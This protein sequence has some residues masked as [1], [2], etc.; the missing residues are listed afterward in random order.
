MI[1]RHYKRIVALV[2]LV[3]MAVLMMGA[4]NQKSDPSTIRIRNAEDLLKLSEECKYDAYSK[5]KTVL[6]EADI[7]LTEVD[8]VPIPTFG[9]TFDGQGH[10]ISGL[11]LS[12]DGRPAAPFRISPSAAPSTPPVRSPRSAP[13]SARTWAP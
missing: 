3:V 7:D 9:G 6:L 1:K 11:S 13:S 8:Y 4:G 2:V 5:D 12:G 10:T